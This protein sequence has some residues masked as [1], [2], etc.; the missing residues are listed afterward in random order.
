MIRVVSHLG[1]VLSLSTGMTGEAER[2]L[3]PTDDFAVLGVVVGVLRGRGEMER[4]RD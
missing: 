3:G 4:L 1:A 2:F